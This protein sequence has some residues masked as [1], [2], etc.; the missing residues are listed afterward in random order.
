MPGTSTI[1]S[2]SVD[3]EVLTKDRL[4]KVVFGL[5]K[6]TSDAGEVTWTINFELFERTKKDEPFGDPIVNLDAVVVKKAHVEQ[7]EDTATAGTFTKTQAEHALGPAAVDAKRFKDG[8]I[9]REKAE[10][11]VERTVAKR[12]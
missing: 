5:D 1:K 11:T 7:A 4:R 9:P 10:S 3:I 12:A 6:V 8:K 2:I